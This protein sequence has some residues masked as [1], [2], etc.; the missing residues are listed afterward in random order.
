MAVV[1]TTTPTLVTVAI[2]NG[3]TQGHRAKRYPQLQSCSQT[4]PML[5]SLPPM[6]APLL[7]SPGCLIPV[8]L[9]M[10]PPMSLISSVS[11]H[12]MTMMK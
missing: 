12:M 5:I 3:G 2:V 4:Q 7:L 10:L 8:P 11:L 9:A 6:T 1:K